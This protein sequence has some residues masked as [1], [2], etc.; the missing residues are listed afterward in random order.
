[1][2]E[3][4]SGTLMVLPTK[5]HFPLEDSS[6]SHSAFN[7]CTRAVASTSC[8]TIANRVL[9]SESAIDA[10]DIDS[11]FTHTRNIAPNSFKN[12]TPHSDL[13]GTVTNIFNEGAILV[14]DFECFHGS[15]P[16][17]L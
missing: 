9:Q 1:M 4:Y 12:P 8:S 7:G 5:A 16:P 3:K 17:Y 2:G 13:L 14:A 15:P 10:G 6:A 11:A